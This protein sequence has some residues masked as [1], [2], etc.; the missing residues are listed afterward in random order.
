M[1]DSI[2][3]LAARAVN[4]LELSSPYVYTPSKAPG[5]AYIAVFGLG[6]LIHVILGFKYKYWI[7]FVTL[8]PGGV[9]ESLSI[10]P[11]P[12]SLFC[13]VETKCELNKTVEVTGWAG[14]LWSSYKVLNSNPFLMQI[15]W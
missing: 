3:D 6:L 5:Y 12:L 2:A 1:L 13:V 15:V 9:R 11:P 8:I 7:A 10:G 14:R 4:H